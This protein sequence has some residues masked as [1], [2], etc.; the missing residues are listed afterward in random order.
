VDTGS[1]EVD[2]GSRRK[3]VTAE[4]LGRAGEPVRQPSRRRDCQK[5]LIFRVFFAAPRISAEIEVFREV[6][7]VLDH[8]AAI[9]GEHQVTYRGM[10]AERFS[11]T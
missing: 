5:A 6:Q 8:K 3:R 1:S 2:T 4:V 10:T 7:C 11:I 9:P